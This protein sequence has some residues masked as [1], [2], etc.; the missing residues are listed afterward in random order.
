MRIILETE[1]LILRMPHHSDAEQLFQLNSNPNV[2]RFIGDGS[3]MTRKESDAYLENAIA[4]SQVDRGYWFAESKDTGEF[5]GW[6]VLKKLDETTMDEI[7]YRL[8][9]DYWGK[10]LATEGIIQIVE[11]AKTKLV[12]KELVAVVLADNTASKNVLRKIGMQYIEDAEYYNSVVE[13][14]QINL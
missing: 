3:I 1:R 5:V 11:Y 8:M 10:G 2:M 7:G 6:Y 13:F 4:I 9:E 12:L 14:Y